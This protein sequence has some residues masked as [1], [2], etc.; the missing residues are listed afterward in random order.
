MPWNLYHTCTTIY[1][2]L[3]HMT[4]PLEFI[5]YD[6]FSNHMTI[7]LEFISYDHFID[8]Q[9]LWQFHWNLYP[10]TISLTFKSFD[11]Y[12]GI[13]IW[14]ISTLLFLSYGN[15]GVIFT[16][17]SF[18]WHLYSMTISLEF[19][20]YMYGHLLTCKL[21]DNCI[22]IHILINKCINCNHSINIIFN[23]LKIQQ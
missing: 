16:L 5:S 19:I 8:M 15:L 6:H 12:I 21:Y 22:G 4:I 14:A 7:Q 18:H 3:N 10:M 20:S 1:W 13:Y 23:L 9:I 11:N 2:H 17:W